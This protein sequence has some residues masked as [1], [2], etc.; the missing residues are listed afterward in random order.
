MDDNIKQD[1]GDVGRAT[2]PT[3]GLGVGVVIRHRKW[4]KWGLGVAEEDNRTNRRGLCG[5]RAHTVSHLVAVYAIFSAILVEAVSSFQAQKNHPIRK[6]LFKRPAPI[7]ENMVYN[8]RLCIQQ[9]KYSTLPATDGTYLDSVV[10]TCCCHARAARV[11]RYMIDVPTRVQGL[12]RTGATQCMHISIQK[13]PNKTNS[14]THSIP[15]S[16]RVMA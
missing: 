13:F 5:M 6:K 7:S 11:K 2:R 4:G 9:T 14:Y 1:E 10:R 8:V 16:N 12:G 3:K 15:S